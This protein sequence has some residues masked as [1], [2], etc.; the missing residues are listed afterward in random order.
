MF[1]N[2]IVGVDNGVEVVREDEE[3]RKFDPA[4][5]RTTRTLWGETIGWG[6]CSKVILVPPH[7]QKLTLH[8]SHSWLTGPRLPY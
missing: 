2:E 4:T 1:S 8:S 3:V 6:S 7:R 5:F